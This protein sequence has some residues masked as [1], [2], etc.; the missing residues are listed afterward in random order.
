[1]NQVFNRPIP[2]KV[3]PPRVLPCGAHGSFIG[4]LLAALLALF[5]WVGR[6]QTDGRFHITLDTNRLPVS[7]S[8]Q[9]L[10]T[11]LSL[12]LGTF[13]NSTNAQDVV[14]LIRGQTNPSEIVSLLTTNF[15]VLFSTNRATNVVIASNTLTFPTNLAVGGVSRSNDIPAYVLIFNHTNPAAATEM[16]IFRA[17]S[18]ST[19]AVTNAFFPS[20]NIRGRVFLSGGDGTSDT[21]TAL[22][23]G[24][25]PLFGQAENGRLRLLP[26]GPPERLVTT[27]LE[28]FVGLDAQLPLRA[29]NGP[30]SFAVVVSNGVATSALSTLGLTNSNGVLVGVPLSN[31]VGTNTLAVTATNAD[32][33]AGNAFG[34]VSLVVRPQNG[35]IFTNASISS[36]TAGV[37]TAF[38]FQTDAPD[39]TGLVFT[40]LDP[41]P[42][43]LTL[44]SLGILSG[45]NVSPGT[46]SFRVLVTATNGEV[47]ALNFQLVTAAPQIFISGTNSSGE[48]E[49]LAGERPFTN[50]LTYTPGFL[51]QTITNFGGNFGLTVATN[52]LSGTSQPSA[53]ATNAP[54]LTRNLRATDTNTGVTAEI[55]A[56]I[57]FVNPPPVFATNQY[58]WLLG[59]TTNQLVE[60]TGSPRFSASSLPPVATSG[61]ATNGLIPITTNPAVLTNLTQ[62]V[63]TSTIVADNLGG[64][65]RGGGRT[66]SSVVITL[67]NPIPGITSANRLLLAAGR[68]ASYTLTATGNPAVF[69]FL[70][71]PP[72]GWAV[73]GNI[74]EGT[75]VGAVQTNIRCRVSNFGLPGDSGTLQTANQ[76]LALL[77]ASSRPA[78]VAYSSPG[79][80]VVG[81]PLPPEGSVFIDTSSGAN[82]AAYGLPPGLSIARETGRLTGTPT[83]PGTYSATVFVQNGRGWIKK[84]VSLTVR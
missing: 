82:V 68:P 46:N 72:A 14:A 30:T 16:G 49:A 12:Q 66:T 45:T 67:T 36:N 48:I 44:S 5:P 75:S 76:T 71:A 52:F 74:L 35:P 60:A 34:A 42:P 59:T 2:L 28:A 81:N 23:L 32:G 22:K 21:N 37:A 64:S 1:M 20:N 3:H 57:V 10:T 26:I 7:S 61:I 38:V 55:T 4:V 78:S 25:G 83:A 62:A 27:N 58:T 6:A 13:T 31:A 9:L 50:T 56:R 70:D 24:L 73:R 53:M 11:N 19:N 8:G 80:L 54:A 17:R 39:P 43:G 65:L 51:P 79:N 63:W 47:R 29:N 41:L 84:T 33:F 15:R 77:I 18:T 40:N 69:E